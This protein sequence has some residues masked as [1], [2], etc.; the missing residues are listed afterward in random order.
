MAAKSTNPDGPWSFASPAHG[1]MTGRGP[2]T[3]PNSQ[4]TPALPEAGNV[5]KQMQRPSIFTVSTKNG[6]VL[7]RY[8]RDLQSHSGAALR[9][10]DWVLRRI[11]VPKLLGEL[12]CL[13]C[14][15]FV[16]SLAS[17]GTYKRC[18]RQYDS[19]SLGSTL[20]SVG[21]PSGRSGSGY[22]AGLF[23]KADRYYC[24]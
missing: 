12:F 23:P 14:L 17:R 4:D 11:L 15:E 19:V 18:T 5:W 9:G 24:S 7:I 8:V 22:M 20:A 10:Y 16:N 1:A 3:S 21:G 6:P 2:L 13:F